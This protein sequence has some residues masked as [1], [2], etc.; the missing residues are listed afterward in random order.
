VAAVRKPPFLKDDYQDPF[1][2]LRKFYF[3]F[4]FI[5]IS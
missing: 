1:S 5:G 2:S 4:D 3:P